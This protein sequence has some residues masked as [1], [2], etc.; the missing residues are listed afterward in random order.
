MMLPLFKT[1]YSIGKS[2]LTLASPSK[3]KEGGADSIIDIALDAGL[4]QLILV[5]DSMHGFLEAK[6]RCEENDIQL[7]FGIR[8]NMCQ[9]YEVEKDRVPFHKIII[10]AKNDDG[11]KNLYK[12][13]S[14]IHCEHNGRINEP[15]LKKLWVKKN[16]SLAIPFYDS[17]IYQNNFKYDA[18]FMHNFNYFNPVFFLEDNALP[19]DFLLKEAVEEFATLNNFKTQQVKSIY[20]RNRKD[21]AAFQTYKMITSRSFSRKASIQSP[22]LNGCGSEEFCMESWLDAH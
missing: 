3:V 9:D 20:Y 8:V 7:I 2:I 4:K 21:L 22:N 16:L 14:A 17:F 10:F 19:Y 5:E 6:R 1:H 18:N 11:V 12:I 15:D 13:Y